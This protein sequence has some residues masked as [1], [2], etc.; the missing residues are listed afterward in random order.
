[1]KDIGIIP[2][3]HKKNTTL[4]VNNIKYFFEQRNI[5]IQI[6][7]ST[8]ADFYSTESLAD[9][10][11]SWCGKLKIIIVVGGDGTILRVGRDLASWDVPILGINLGQKGFLAEIEV[12]KMER[13][14][15]YIATDQYSTQERIMLE[16]RL[17]RKDEE[18][19][20]YLAFNDIV[21]ARGP[22]SRN[23]KVDALV[24]DDFMESYSGD[25]IIVATPTG[26]TA[27]SLAAG[28]PIINPT[29]DLFVITPICPHSLYNRSVIINGTDTMELKVDSRQVKVVLTV[30]GQVRFALEDNDKITIC[31]AK[32][33]VKMVCFHDYSFYRLLHQKLKA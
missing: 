4:V 3:W 15:Q 5:P 18:L 14:L 11:N 31:R 20:Y 12:E 17:Q 29:M 32:E 22:F 19:G 23:I 33:K 9:Q 27:Y 1:M 26:S 6:A 25:G 2:N 10:L 16:A 30:D 28:G 21:I 24:N 8:D 7:S 13:F